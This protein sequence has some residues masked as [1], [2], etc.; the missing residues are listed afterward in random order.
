MSGNR[1]KVVIA[2]GSG[3]LGQALAESLI[4]DGYEV[5]ILSR[6]K[7]DASNYFGEMVYWDAQTIGEWCE[8]LEGALA[9]YNLTGRSVDCRYTQKNKDLILHS[10]LDATKVLGEAVTACQ[11]PPPVWLNASTATIY[12]DRRG[13]LP[14]HDEDS[15]GDAKGFS[16][17]VGR[18]W[19]KVFFESAQ[20][21]VRQLAMRIS[22]VLGEGGG[23]FPVMRRLTRLGLGG[24]QGPGSQWISW[25]HIDDWVG[26]AKFLMINEQLAGPVNLASPNPVTNAQFMRSMRQEFAPLGIGFPAPTPAIFI[27]AIFLGTAPELVLKSRKVISKKLKEANYSFSFSEIISAVQSLNQ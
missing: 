10:R 15:T 17:E 8:E 4:G 1:G 18:A 16:E 9:L 7:K 23:A 25:L 22:I 2:G 26:I 20:E 5:T 12:D 13:N 11:E 24:W 19:E 3:F 27:G 6:K 21:G 14:P